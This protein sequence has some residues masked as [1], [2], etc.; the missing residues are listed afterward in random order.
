MKKWVIMLTVLLVT[1]LVVGGVLYYKLDTDHRNEIASLTIGSEKVVSEKN[2]VIELLE[3]EADALTADLSAKEAQLALLAEQV[4]VLTASANDFSLQIGVLTTLDDNNNAEIN[5][6]NNQIKNLNAEKESQVASLG[7]QIDEMKTM[8]AEKYEELVRLMAQNESLNAEKDTQAAFLSSQI[9]ELRFTVDEKDQEIIRLMAQNES[10]SAEKDAQTA[11]MNSQIDELKSAAHEKDQE[12]VRLLARNESLSIES[13][14]KGQSIEA[15]TRQAEN[16]IAKQAEYT[17]Q[18]EN[19]TARLD[20][21]TASG[22]VFVQTAPATQHTETAEKTVASEV[23][24]TEKSYFIQ[25]VYQK[26]GITVSLNAIQYDEKNNCLNFKG[27]LINQSKKP[28]QVKVTGLHINNWST[29]V[30]DNIYLSAEPGRND[31]GK[32]AGTVDLEEPASITKRNDIKLIEGEL[33]IS[34]GKE[35]EAI[36]FS[37]TDFD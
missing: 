26:N 35:T 14:Q 10:L 19:L 23:K 4:S 36:P 2:A 6:L 34:F 24:E 18:I 13:V 25:T 22:S 27:T 32:I 11:F 7:V 5:R 28:V 31:R 16:H 29:N 37:F 8:V 3:N 21:I 33:S 15:L 1:V 9:D 12:I 17:A 20:Q 30:Y